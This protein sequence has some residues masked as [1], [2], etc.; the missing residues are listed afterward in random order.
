MSSP[1]KGCFIQV[2]KIHQIITDINL[3]EIKGT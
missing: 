2:F 3:Q 1:Q